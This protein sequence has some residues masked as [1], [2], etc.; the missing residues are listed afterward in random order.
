MATPKQIELRIKYAKTSINSL[1]KKVSM[2]KNKVKK[3][4][5]EMKKAKCAAAKPAKKAPAK[6]KVAKKK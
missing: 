4:E 3:L 6:K 5:E 2:Y 1:T